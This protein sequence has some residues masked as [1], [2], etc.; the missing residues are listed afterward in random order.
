MQVPVHVLS[1]D[2]VFLEVRVPGHW[3]AVIV[4]KK[5]LLDQGSGP[6][7]GGCAFSQDSRHLSGRCPSRATCAL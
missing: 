6:V 5:V 1:C 3:G 7:E 2:L 4:Y